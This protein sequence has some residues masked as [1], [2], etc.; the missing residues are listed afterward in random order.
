MTQTKPQ[1]RVRDEGGVRCVSFVDRSIIDEAVIQQIGR[2][3][4]AQVEGMSKPR[5]VIDFEGVQLLSSAAL[6][7]LIGVN[8]RVAERGGALRLCGIPKTIFEV[9][10]ITK[11][12]RLFKTDDTL[13][14]ALQGLA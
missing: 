3:L 13:T 12:D 5:M 8:K 7:V 11:L 6:G 9:F 10:R 2:E 1:I 4:M 14:Q